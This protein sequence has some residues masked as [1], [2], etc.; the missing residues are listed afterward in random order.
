MTPQD[1][2]LK[3]DASL[4]PPPYNDM[5]YDMVVRFMILGIVPCAASGQRRATGGLSRG[6]FFGS[7]LFHML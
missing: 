4:P 1:S 3:R 6:A 7:P 2:M 5:L